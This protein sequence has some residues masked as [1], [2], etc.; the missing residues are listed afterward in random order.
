[1]GRPHEGAVTS[2]VSCH[3]GEVNY[4]WKIPISFSSQEFMGDRCRGRFGDCQGAEL[5]G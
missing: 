4:T 3:R 5:S 1:M 2:H